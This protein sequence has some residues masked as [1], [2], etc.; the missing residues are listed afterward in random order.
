MTIDP[1]N[2]NPYQQAQIRLAATLPPMTEVD[3]AII[4][5]SLGG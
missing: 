2:P 3:L 4:K 5:A 1:P